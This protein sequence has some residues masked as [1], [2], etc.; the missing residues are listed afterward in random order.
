MTDPMTWCDECG[1]RKS[2][3]DHM[4]NQKLGPVRAAKAWLQK[5]C[6]HGKKSGCPIQYACGVDVVGIKRAIAEAM[7]RKA[8]S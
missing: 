8:A 1:R 4:R 2:P 6:P 3:E 7:R 5:K